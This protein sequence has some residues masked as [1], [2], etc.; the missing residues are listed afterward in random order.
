LAGVHEEQAALGTLGAQLTQQAAVIDAAAADLQAADA[1]LAQRHADAQR[2]RE[3]A[4]EHAT[5]A[6][7]WEQAQA[8]ALA[9]Y[10]ARAKA[11]A[12]VRIAHDQ[13]T[14]LT[15][16]KA[17]HEAA[18][19][20]AQAQLCIARAALTLA[21]NHLDYT[22]IRAATEGVVGERTIRVGHHIEAGQPLMAIVPLDAAYVIA[23]F[24][25]TDIA[26]IHP[27]QAVDID[28]D[29][30]SGRTVH[31]TVIGIAPGSGAQFA[32]LPPENATGNFTKVVQ[33]IPVKITID[34]AA[35]SAWPLRSG[36]SVIARVHT[37]EANRQANNATTINGAKTP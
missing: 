18:I 6:Q 7:R 35:L 1:A 2:Y 19:A 14:V 29:A 26:A 10:A 4:A 13:Q 20:R 8:L 37:R 9:A 33:R 30:Y 34:Q 21:R 31:G 25:E 16:Q 36:M 12:D 17:Q 27:G 3:L 23:N 28:V 24:K 32:L 11:N 15:H 5:S 22:V